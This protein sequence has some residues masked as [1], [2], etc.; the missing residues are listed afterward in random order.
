MPQS[1]SRRDRWISASRDPGRND[2][3]Q[4]KARADSELAVRVGEMQLD[5]LFG[6]EKA[7]GH[8]PIA[9]VTSHQVA[10]APLRRGQCGETGELE[11]RWT[12]A[13]RTLPSPRRRRPHPRAGRPRTQGITLRRLL[14]RRPR[15]P[16]RHHPGRRRGRGQPHHRRRDPRAGKLP[17]L[18]QPGR[19]GQQPNPR[20]PVHLSGPAPG[21]AGHRRPQQSDDGHVHPLVAG[22]GDSQPEP[23]SLSNPAQ[24]VKR[25]ARSG[26][27][28]ERSRCQSPRPGVPPAGT[29]DNSWERTGESR[30]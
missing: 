16:D 6:Y 3:R 26:N 10:N 11:L 27:R 29:G 28:C 8:L 21:A 12:A 2:R 4:L 22:S 30:P 20:R 23:A 24:A 17:P 19:T 14:P 1:L 13:A 15:Q 9:H 18:L 5:R 25:S 7:L